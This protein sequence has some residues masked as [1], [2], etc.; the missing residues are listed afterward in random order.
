MRRFGSV[1]ALI[2]PPLAVITAILA[3]WEVASIVSHFPAYVLPRP[4]QIVAGLFHPGPQFVHYA[5]ITVQETLIGFIIGS[6]VGLLLAI[7]IV[8]S[9]MARRSVYPL[10]IL[11]QTVPKIVLAPIFIIWFGY[12]LL[13]KEMLVVVL[14]F[15]P[16]TVDA[17]HG[18]TSM[19]PTLIELLQSVS[20]SRWEILWKIQLPHSLPYVFSGLKVATTL[21]VIGAVV[22]EWAG[23]NAGLGFMILNSSAQL[24]TVRMFVGVVAISVIGLALFYAVSRLEEWV[25]PWREKVDVRRP[26]G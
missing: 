7:A 25:L 1:L 13:P 24:E 11:F 21:S 10:I 16:V 26:V 4:S 18:L 23:A 14:A 12:G 5:W 3:A 22:G 20:A 2:V 15:F 19:D 6:T 9:P 17:I 8:L